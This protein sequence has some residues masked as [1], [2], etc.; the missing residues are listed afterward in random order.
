MMYILNMSLEIYQNKVNE[1]IDDSLKDNQLFNPSVIQ[2]PSYNWEFVDQLWIHYIQKYEYISRYDS[3]FV[4]P[5]DLKLSSDIIFTQ[6]IQEQKKLLLIVSSK[7]HD[8]IFAVLNDKGFHCLQIDNIF[9][10]TVCDIILQNDL[11]PL[12][13][14][15]AIFMF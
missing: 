10:D 13:T 12:L 14:T 2:V 3:N 15:L 11:N 6:F 5:K 9:F 4:I 8:P 1:I 7:K